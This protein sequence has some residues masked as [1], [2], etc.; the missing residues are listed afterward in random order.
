M[1][2]SYLLVD[3]SGPK[4]ALVEKGAFLPL[5][6]FHRTGQTDRAAVH[7]TFANEN[8]KLTLRDWHDILGHLSPSAVTHLEKSS[9]IR[10]TDSTVASEVRCAVCKECKSEA[11]SFARGGRSQKISGEMVH[12]DLEG[13][14]NP[15]V[16]GSQYFRVIVDEASRYKRVMGLKMFVLCS[17]NTM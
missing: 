14:F 5:Q 12:T 1:G 10:I 4:I 13:L 7:A 2:K 9:L 15:D 16:S 6:A 3:G 11:C 17:R 8:R